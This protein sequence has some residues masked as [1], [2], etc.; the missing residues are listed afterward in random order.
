MLMDLYPLLSLPSYK[1]FVFL[2]EPPSN[3]ENTYPSTHKTGRCG[4]AQADDTVRE[5]RRVRYT[6]LVI[7]TDRQRSRW[8]CL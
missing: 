4:W 8:I 7:T 6:I 1:L 3:V 5:L 2:C